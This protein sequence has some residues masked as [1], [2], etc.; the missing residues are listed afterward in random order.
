MEIKEKNEMKVVGKSRV[1][2]DSALTVISNLSFDLSLL[3]SF[4]NSSTITPIS[5]ELLSALCE[6]SRILSDTIAVIKD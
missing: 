2:P 1:L 6:Q 4:Q 3:K 5:K